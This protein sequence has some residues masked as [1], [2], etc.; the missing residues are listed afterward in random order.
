MIKQT[1]GTVRRAKTHFP[2]GINPSSDC[3][4]WVVDDIGVLHVLSENTDQTG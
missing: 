3:A 1:T 2:L 4:H